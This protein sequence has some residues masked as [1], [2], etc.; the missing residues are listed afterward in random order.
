MLT[1][2]D[3]GATGLTKRCGLEAITDSTIWIDLVNPTPEEDKHIEAALSIEIPTRAEAREIEASNRFY[4]ERS[5][6]YMT[7]FV[8]YNI[9]QVN[10]GT[11]N[12]TLRFR[13]LMCW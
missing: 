2:Y 1:I 4:T 9:E 12:I 10:P 8:M 6:H 11:S 7:A 13:S 3:G 5:A